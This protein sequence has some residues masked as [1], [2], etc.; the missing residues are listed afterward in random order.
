MKKHFFLIIAVIFYFS[1]FGTHQAAAQTLDEAILAAAVRISGELPSGAAVA[2]IDFRCVT[3]EVS[4]YVINELQGAL[5]RNRRIN[6]VR[7]NQSQLTDIGRALSYNAAGDIETESA[8]IIGQMLNAQFLITGSLVIT[9]SVNRITFNAYDTEQAQRRSQYAANIT[10]DARIQQELAG[11]ERLRQEQLRQEQLRQEEAQR[12]QEAERQEHLRQEQQRLEQQREEQRRQEQERREQQRQEQLSPEQRQQRQEQL[13]REQER[14]ELFENY[15]YVPHYN[16]LGI[17]ASTVLGESLISLTVHGT[18]SPLQY[19]FIEAGCD[20]GFINTFLHSIYNNNSRIAEYG[21][22][23]P[24]NDV[25]KS[26]FSV[27][28]FLHV[29]LFVPF[30][31]SGG[32]FLSAGAG[33]MAGW[34]TFDYGT[35]AI[36][37]FAANITLGVNLFNFLDISYTARLDFNDGANHKLAIGYIYRFKN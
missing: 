9:G 5:T 35:T 34:Y 25:P 21:G 29:G 36:E 13:N 37:T 24:T 4:R 26:Y 27:Y 14:R 12:R 30:G 3:E 11:Q 18:F 23:I 28:P 1:F 10:S 15:P 19:F 33:Y 32:L 6:L 17:S 2:V 7:A 31:V 16:T 22:Y 20:F 8:Q